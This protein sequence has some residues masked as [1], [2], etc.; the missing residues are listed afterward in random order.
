VLLPYCFAPRGDLRVHFAKV[1][2]SLVLQND[3]PPGANVR[4][5]NISAWQLQIQRGR[6]KSFPLRAAFR[7][8]VTTS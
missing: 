3:P 7:S 2:A 1:R 8:L 6:C 5:A 4:F